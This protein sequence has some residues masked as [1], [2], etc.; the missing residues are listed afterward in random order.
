M[1]KAI[2]LCALVLAV[3][4]SV[5]AY[6][7]KPLTR[8]MNGNQRFVKDLTR[9]PQRSVADRKILVGGQEPFA[10]VVSCS[11]S[12]VPPEIVFDQDLGDLFIVRTA[13]PVLDAVAIGSIEYAVEHLHA[14]LVIVMGH[15]QCGAVKA[16]I[17][18]V[19]FPPHISDIVTAITPAV[20]VARQKSGDLLSNSIEENVRRVKAQLDTESPVLAKAKRHHH[21][22]VVGGVYDLKT[23]R[24]VLL[25]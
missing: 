24:V 19:T 22:E 8:L 7:G 20:D 15:S 23:G 4:V 14:S 11:D 5:H 1:R 16:A 21:L 17:S 25:R 13:G 18:G 3:P 6:T 10:I 2:L 9:A 12:R